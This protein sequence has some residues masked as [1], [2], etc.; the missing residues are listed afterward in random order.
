MV[1]WGYL[2]LDGNFSRPTEI[3][4]VRCSQSA[5]KG[6]EVAAIRVKGKEIINDTAAEDQ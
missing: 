4:P 1:G 2:W 6:E 3:P 5:K